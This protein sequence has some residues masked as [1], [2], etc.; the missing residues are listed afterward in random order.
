MISRKKN[1]NQPKKYTFVENQLFLLSGGS[2][3]MNYIEQDVATIF[4]VI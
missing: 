2:I 3:I 4:E 1:N